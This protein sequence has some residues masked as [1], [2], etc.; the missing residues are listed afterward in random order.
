[1]RVTV[2]GAGT[3]YSGSCPPPGARAPGFTATF[4][5]GRLPARVEY[6]WV[7]TR[8]SVSDPGWRTLSFPAG[9]GKTRQARV[10]LTVYRGGPAAGDQVVV[11]V[12]D[13]E[14]TTS[15]AVPFSVDCARTASKTPSGGPSSS[16]PASVPASPSGSP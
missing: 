4:T 8:G 9:G 1:M 2:A 10:T 14:D 16:P 15:N 13:P 11:K 12:R 5:V 3:E 6:R 7:T